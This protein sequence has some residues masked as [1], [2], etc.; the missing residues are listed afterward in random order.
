LQN[1]RVVHGDMVVE[2]VVCLEDASLV[3]AVL[4]SKRVQGWWLSRLCLLSQR[5]DISSVEVDI[6]SHF[7]S[8][9]LYYNTSWSYWARSEK[10]IRGDIIYR[11]K[12]ECLKTQNR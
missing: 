4:T 7:K 10:E 1:Q 3:A 5:C 12:Y 9:N 6:A 11:L 8:Y 2:L